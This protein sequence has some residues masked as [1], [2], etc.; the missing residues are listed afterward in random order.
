MLSI[1]VPFVSSCASTRESSVSRSVPAAAPTPHARPSLSEQRLLQFNERRASGRGLFFTEDE[2]RNAKGSTLVTFLRRV[3]SVRVVC[4]AAGCVVRMSRTTG[5]CST[6]LI[7][8]GASAAYSTDLMMSTADVV[9]IE[10]Y[11]TSSE[12]PVEFMGVEN[13]CGTIV[14]WTRSGP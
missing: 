9:G 3:P 12:T 5:E 2:L 8:D 11:R 14:I 7:V 1:L 10:V 4:E 6:A 13:S